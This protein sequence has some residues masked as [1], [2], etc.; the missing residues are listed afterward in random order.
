MARRS[1]IAATHGQAGF[2]QRGTERLPIFSGQR[3]E[4]LACQRDRRLFP[5]SIDFR[6]LQRLQR[7]GFG[8]GLNRLSGQRRDFIE[9]QLKLLD[10]TGRSADR[11]RS[12]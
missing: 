1:A 5:Y 3:S 12:G 11:A 8:N 6:L 4:F 10:Y 7:I 2:L 9:L